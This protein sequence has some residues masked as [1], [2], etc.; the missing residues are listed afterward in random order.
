M[1]VCTRLPKEDKQSHNFKIV[2]YDIKISGLMI[3]A[4]KKLN[5]I[6]S[7][8]KAASVYYYEQVRDFKTKHL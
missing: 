1:N 3:G 8:Q 5:Q 6:E 2:L 7:M 4:L